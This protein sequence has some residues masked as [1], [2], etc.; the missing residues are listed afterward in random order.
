M[1]KLLLLLTVLFG[2]V[3]TPI[4]T[5]MAE[6]GTTTAVTTE[7]GTEL[8]SGLVETQASPEQTLVPAKA[9]FAIDDESGKIL[10]TQNAEQQLGIAS[11]TKIVTAYIVL[12]QIKQGKLK[13]SD[14]IAPSDYAIWLSQQIGL[15]NITMI[16][17]TTVSVRDLFNALMIQ[18]AN[19][20]AVM[21]A[22]KISGSEPAFVDL[23]K[24]TLNAW[25]ITEFHIVN[26]SGLDNKYLGD[27]LYPGS[28][29]EDGNTMRAQ[30][31][32]W[33]ARKLMDDFPDVLDV[34]KQTEVTFDK[35]GKNEQTLH[36]FNYM[37]KGYAT[38]RPG[39][40]GLKTGTTDLAGPSFVAT[41]NENG[42]RII[43]VVLGA[44]GG[45]ADP[46]ARFKATNT[47]MNY[48]YGNWK[49]TSVLKKD[50]KIDDLSSYPVLDGKASKTNL[51]VKKDYSLV[52]PINAD[53]S[54]V[55]I[56]VDK[57]KKELYAPIKEGQT[58]ADG[59]MTIED[60]LGYIKNQKIATFELVATKEIEKSGP[61]KVF[62]NHFVRFVNEKL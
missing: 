40:D 25:G 33:V 38:Y 21:F 51:R 32:A 31:V 34:T 23:M 12:D 11:I 7:A 22:E 13:W 43:T 10:Y 41:T 42:F 24:A 45:D 9:A 52:V 35:G 50:Q 28:T 56:T 48:V 44:D 26:A 53:K 29:A 16:R 58:I 37:L 4:S 61:L 15:S 6:D 57:P 17:D 18:S 14:Q 62:W 27:N 47:L 3:V 54:A 30:D 49:N 2:A 60:D 36:T 20:A 46:Y 5:T 39:V 19:T 1:K 8:T 59:T 55:K